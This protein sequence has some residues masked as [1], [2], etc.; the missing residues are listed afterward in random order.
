M[1][2]RC[3]ADVGVRSCSQVSYMFLYPNLRSLQSLYQVYRDLLNVLALPFSPLAS[4]GLQ[5]RQVA[6]I[7]GRPAPLQGQALNSKLAASLQTKVCDFVGMRFFFCMPEFV[8]PG[9]GRSGEQRR[10]R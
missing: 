1:L 10:S 6:E 4:E 7:A 3:A 9:C 8:A 5:Q 2:S